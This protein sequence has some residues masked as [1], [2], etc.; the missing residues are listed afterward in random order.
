M[1]NRVKKITGYLSGL[2][3]I[4]HKKLNEKEGLPFGSDL[5]KVVE[6][7]PIEKA[8]SYIE[9][10]M[11]KGNKGQIIPR[12]NEEENVD[13]DKLYEK[14]ATP[15]Q[16]LKNLPQFSDTELFTIA[17]SFVP[18]RDPTE[19]IITQKDQFSYRVSQ[20]AGKVNQVLIIFSGGWLDFALFFDTIQQQPIKL[21][22]LVYAGITSFAFQRSVQFITP[23]VNTYIG[24]TNF[25][26]DR[27]GHMITSLSII[28]SVAL[29]IFQRRIHSHLIESI[30]EKFEYGKIPYRNLDRCENFNKFVDVV[31]TSLN[32]ER[33]S[34]YSNIF[35][36]Y[37]TGEDGLVK[38]SI[39]SL[40]EMAQRAKYNLHKCRL[41]NQY[42][43][44]EIWKLDINNIAKDY[45]FHSDDAIKRDWTSLIYE[46]NR[47]PGSL[48]WITNSDEL[49]D[50]LDHKNDGSY[51]NAH[52][53]KEFLAL[54]FLALIRQEQGIL[55]CII[56]GNE[57]IW[58]IVEKLPDISNKFQIIQSPVLSLSDLKIYFKELYQPK[59]RWEF[60]EL[61]DEALDLLLN[62]FDRRNLLG[63]LPNSLV[64]GLEKL[65]V[66]VK[67]QKEKLISKTKTSH[68]LKEQTENIKREK[69]EKKLTE[70][71]KIFEKTFKQWIEFN[72]SEKDI[73]STERLVLAKRLIIL[74]QTIIPLLKEK[75]AKE[76]AS[77][78]ITK[79]D[80]YNH[81]SKVHRRLP[82]FTTETEIT[83]I[84]EAE[85]IFN[86]KFIGRKE[87]FREICLSWLTW[88]QSP[89]QNEEKSP[90][91]TYFFS[92]PPGM[93]KSA[94]S[95]IIA[96][97]HS[98]TFEI[99]G[100]YQ[101]NIRIFYLP[102][103]QWDSILPNEIF[104]QI[105]EFILTNPTGIIVLEEIEKVPKI[106]L[107][108]FLELLG[109]GPIRYNN[110]KKIAS[111]ID[112]SNIIFIL[113]SNL[114][115]E[116]LLKI[117]NYEEG[118]EMLRELAKEEFGEAFVGRIN[119]TF[120]F[121]PLSKDEKKELI[122]KFLNEIKENFIKNFSSI[123][124]EDSLIEHYVE[125]TNTLP[126]FRELRAE[127]R[128]D[129]TEVLTPY[130]DKKKG[131]VLSYKKVIK[132]KTL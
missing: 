97:V 127:M 43:Q 114:G 118:K 27:Y 45:D 117:H 59:D 111:T 39:E 37:K 101:D 11:K 17:D 73:H 74:K 19:R 3:S 80:V 38:E 31:T 23:L 62:E 72:H 34:Y 104:S 85:A 103:A 82:L 1:K 131:I 20:L 71:R 87:I 128:R 49:F 55:R 24:D 115:S 77:L 32:M 68:I 83:R 57:R 84:K 4:F 35:V 28:C 94:L 93:G 52:K 79:E 78:S 6:A 89:K 96:E 65:T 91:L 119:N 60:P 116:E 18:S 99:Y 124:F 130:F 81:I 54:Q 107:N 56:S 9:A 67:L 100:R 21:T 42:A 125:R 63:Q 26:E 90:A 106:H 29:F 14:V 25:V 40:Q 10:N 105:Y 120:P 47:N 46:H 95:Q 12:A 122:N 126:D 44:L 2:T 88:R 53:S 108:K 7:Y 30:S 33:N 75:I 15:E 86:T 16:T 13:L 70:A 50:I 22:G 129:L 66:D 48:L 123:T 113:T 58:S 69:R 121:I 41:G 132:F 109:T 51:Y 102:N 61:S 92:G 8:L 98:K 110:R 112:R 64:P 36:S 76:L 5:L